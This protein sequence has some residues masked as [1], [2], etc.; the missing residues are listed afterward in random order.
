MSGAT[1]QM[2]S[3]EYMWIVVREHDDSGQG[4]TTGRLPFE[5]DGTS[6]REPDGLAPETESIEKLFLAPDPNM[7]DLKGETERDGLPE[8][9]FDSAEGSGALVTW[10]STTSQDY[11]EQCWFKF[12][13]VEM[14]KTRSEMG[15]SKQDTWKYRDFIILG[16]SAV[17]EFVKDAFLG[18]YEEVVAENDVVN[19]LYSEFGPMFRQTLY[20]MVKISV[21][22][23]MGETRCQNL[24]T[25]SDM[26]NDAM[27]T[28]S[29]VH[30]N[31]CGVSGRVSRLRI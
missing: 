8:Q 7:D 22:L 25:P 15:M 10:V 16:G 14:C 11:F 27:L 13:G 19:G 30:R 31:R 3:Q 18:P 9:K 24:G 23:K 21:Q 28:L 20:T 6:D 1:E 4:S 26:S 2:I 29:L 5:L 17:V 12:G